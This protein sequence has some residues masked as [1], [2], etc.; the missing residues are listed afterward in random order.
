LVEPINLPRLHA[1]KFNEAGFSQI[2][3]MLRSI[4]LWQ[5]QHFLDVADT[6]RLLKQKI[7]DPQTRWIRE[8]LVN[9]NQPKT[10]QSIT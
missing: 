6:E 1:L 7:Q 5:I 10:H 9:F 3:E 4:Y 2:G 8:R